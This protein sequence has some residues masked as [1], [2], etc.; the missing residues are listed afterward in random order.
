VNLYRANHSNT[1]GLSAS[2][3][4]SGVHNG[5]N[6]TRVNLHGSGITKSALTS[7]FIAAGDSSNFYTELLNTIT[8]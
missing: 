1:T 2:A 5:L 3:I 6:I 4:V 7:A 8:Y